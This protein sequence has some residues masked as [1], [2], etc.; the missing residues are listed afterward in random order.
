MYRNLP[1]LTAQLNMIK[2]LY[3]HWLAKIKCDRYAYI[4]Y[5]E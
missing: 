1:D 3:E 4:D 5:I 2:V